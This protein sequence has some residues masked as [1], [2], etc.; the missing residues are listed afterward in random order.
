MLPLSFFPLLINS[1]LLLETK[2]MKCQNGKTFSFAGRK[3]K[4]SPTETH[5]LFSPNVSSICY[6]KMRKKKKR[7]NLHVCV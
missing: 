3:K 4:F 5:I 7:N 1:F 6:V 2:F